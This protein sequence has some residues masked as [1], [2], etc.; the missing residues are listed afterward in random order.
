M[1]GWVGEIQ[2]KTSRHVIS[3]SQLLQHIFNILDTYLVV[4][5]RN[6]ASIMVGSDWRRKNKASLVPVSTA[7]DTSRNQSSALDT[8]LT[9]S[10]ILI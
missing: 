9:M 4:L 7:S 5:L 6:N 10:L 8:L 3:P 2:Y 1:G